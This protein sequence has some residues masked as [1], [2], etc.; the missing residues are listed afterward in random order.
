MVER[1]TGKRL[2]EFRADNGGEYQNDSF[3]AYLAQL[4][5]LPQKLF[6]ILLS[7]MELVSE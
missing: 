1:Q 5:I 6:L 4:G 7:R 3:G 2:K